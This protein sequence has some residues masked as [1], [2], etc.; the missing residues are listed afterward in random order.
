MRL[1]MNIL[2]FIF[3]GFISGTLWLLAGLILAITVIGLD[4]RFGPDGSVQ[5]F[6]S[7]ACALS[8]EEGQRNPPALVQVE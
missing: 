3:G 5:R 1:L 7:T 8:W 2:W 4:T 6:C